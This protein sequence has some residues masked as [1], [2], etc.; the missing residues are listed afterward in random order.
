MASTDKTKNDQT[1]KGKA[2]CTIK[3][4][5][6]LGEASFR[7][8]VAWVLLTNFDNLA[9]TAAAFYALG[10]AAIIVLAHFVGAHKTK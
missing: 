7:F 1:K 5:A 6:W 10:T 4:I 9:T 2:L 8:F 3:S